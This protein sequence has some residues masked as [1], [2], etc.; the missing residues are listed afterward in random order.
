MA[1]LPMAVAFFN[2]RP[3]HLPTDSLVCLGEDALVATPQNLLQ[4]LL[5]VTSMSFDRTSR[6]KHNAA[7][8]TGRNPRSTSAGH[9]GPL[10]FPFF[11]CAKP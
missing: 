4:N 3:M 9:A 10:L 2:G 7:S 11:V 8:R 1:F 6:I 5:I